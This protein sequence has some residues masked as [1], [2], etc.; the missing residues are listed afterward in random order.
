M[1]WPAHADSLLP[2]R[3]M[4]SPAVTMIGSWRQVR[5]IS[6]ID[7]LRREQLRTTR[8]HAP[9]LRRSGAIGKIFVS[10][11]HKERG[12][13]AVFSFVVHRTTA[14]GG[15]SNWWTRGLAPAGPGDGI[16]AMGSQ[17]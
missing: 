14:A 7:G 12:G 1:D 5:R 6:K 8:L 11:A 2:L 13:S 9:R 3:M 16:D 17:R 4:R 10:N 15:R